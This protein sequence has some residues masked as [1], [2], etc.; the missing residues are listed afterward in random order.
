MLFNFL[1]FAE[2]HS[3]NITYHAG[4]DH[5]SKSRGHGQCG[6]EVAVARPTVGPEM[7]QEEQQIRMM[8]GT[9]RDGPV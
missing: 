5:F 9:G 8:G 6:H 7:P 4:D 3:T 1:S 2:N